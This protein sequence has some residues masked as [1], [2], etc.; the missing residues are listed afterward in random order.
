MKRAAIVVAVL[1]IAGGA[2]AYVTNGGSGQGT[3]AAGTADPVTIGAGTP[4]SELYPGGTA[5]VAISVSNPNPGA[6]HIARLVL[7]DGRGASGFDVSG[8][9]GTCTTPALSFADNTNGGLG[10]DVPPGVHDFDL[11][12]AVAMG[13]DADDGC[14][15]ATFTVYLESAG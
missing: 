5:D 13:S 15:G 2:L 3:Q 10:W 12:D 7:D 6:V 4:T 11:T 14:Q 8:G 9:T 1:A